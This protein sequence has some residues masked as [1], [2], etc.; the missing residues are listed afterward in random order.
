LETIMMLN[1]AQLGQ[2]PFANPGGPGS[3]GT[4]WTQPGSFG[5]TGVAPL[6]AAYGGNPYGFG[7]P[8]ATLGA[9]PVDDI[10]DDIA[11]RVANEIADQAASGAAA[12]F[13]AQIPQQ[14]GQ[15]SPGGLNAK[16][17]LNASRVTDSVH[18][19]VKQNTLQVCRQA[20]GH[21]L[22]VLQQQLQQQQ[23]THA[24]PQPYGLGFGHGG[25][26]APG[27][28]AYGQTQPFGQQNVAQLAPVVAAILGML[29]AQGQGIGQTP[30]GQPQFG[31][32]GRLI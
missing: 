12:L 7:S 31:A 3:W 19:S 29:Q 18:E 26:G 2:N 17:W 23:W 27:L 13:Q 4:Q 25:I 5:A 10:A 32:A 20:V 9:G 21:L 28:A 11:E 16:R 6:L 8:M 22:G 1:P 30:Y 15:H 24:G 14:P